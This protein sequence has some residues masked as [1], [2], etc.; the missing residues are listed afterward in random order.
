MADTLRT[1]VSLPLFPLGAVLYPDGR[2][3]LRVFEVR[4]L[5]MVRKCHTLGAPFGVVALTSGT[6]VRQAGAAPETLAPV[7]TLCHVEALASPQPGLLTIQCTG[8]QRFRTTRCERRINGLWIADV[9]LLPAPPATPLPDDLKPCA[10]ALERL[11]TQL[12]AR[13][14][15]TPG[16]VPRP[17]HLDD[18]GWVANRWC[19]LL[20]F[21]LQHKQLL[22]ELD[23]PVVRLELVWD[24]LQQ[25]GIGAQ[26]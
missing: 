26:G 21:P 5:D 20:P 14:P 3:S 4:Y 9:Q 18:C 17:W 22:L 2:L 6:E 8:S 7:G 24:Y 11:L 15:D 19:E 12:A 13:A 25:S 10:L 16:P 1:L 23:S